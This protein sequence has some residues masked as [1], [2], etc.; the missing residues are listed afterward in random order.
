[1]KPSS[2]SSNTLT[3]LH[4]LEGD[5]VCLLDSWKKTHTDGAKQKKL[6]IKQCF[7]LSFGGLP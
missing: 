4:L 2:E 7:S 1:V 3:L 5:D 6:E